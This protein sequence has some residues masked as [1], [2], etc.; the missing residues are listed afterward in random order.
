MPTLA[1]NDVDLHFEIGGS[2]PPLMLLAGM[3]S[4]SA[5]WAPILPTLEAH[6]TVI[7]PDNRT[8]GRTTPPEAPVSVDI[9]A[10]DALD[11]A[12][13]LGVDSV[14]ILGHSLGGIIGTRLAMMAPDRVQRLVLLAS[15]PVRL[16]RTDALFA[17]LA[18]LRGPGMAPDLWL[19]AFF[20]WLFHPRFYDDPQRLDAAVVQS[21]AYPHAQSPAA[22]AHQ[23]AAVGAFD[24]ETL[25]A[26]PA[27]PVLA[28]L[29]DDDLLVPPEAAM[30][31]LSGFADIRIRQLAGAGHSLHWDA[32]DAVLDH[33]LPFL[34]GLGGR[35]A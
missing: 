13:H 12:R 1:L 35:T 11:L 15:A 22:M 14:D 10:R 27:C 23:A 7:R 29:A 33:V 30:R 24:P 9:W 5:S 26:G 28:L 18:A 20:P 17:V 6:F 3:A 19:R 4:D 25:R 8:C 31:A 2:G 16:P 32:P 21:L 34:T